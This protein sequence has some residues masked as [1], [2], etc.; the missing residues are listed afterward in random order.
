MRC[1]GLGLGP[2]VA[3][4]TGKVASRPKNRYVTGFDSQP[5]LEAGV[6]TFA[7]APRTRLAASP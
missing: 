6:R 4:P 2:E 3:L 1:G 5:R 7:C